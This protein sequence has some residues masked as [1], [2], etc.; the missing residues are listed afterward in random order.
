MT[1][2]ALVLALALVCFPAKADMAT[3]AARFVGRGNFT[4]FPGPWCGAAMSSWY[5]LYKGRNPHLLRARDWARVG[6]PSSVRPGA[7]VVWPHHV[8]VIGR[9]G[10]IISGNGRGNRVTSRHRPLHGVIAI[11]ALD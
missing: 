5:A 10:A 8:G 9:D 1:R 7:I 4:G 2:A 11:R 3:I 6:R